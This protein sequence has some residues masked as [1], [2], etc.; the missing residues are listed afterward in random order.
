MGRR[1]RGMGR[2]EGGMEVPYDTI[3]AYV[4]VCGWWKDKE[5]TQGKD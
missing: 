5:Q 3:G 1:E 2:R 4:I